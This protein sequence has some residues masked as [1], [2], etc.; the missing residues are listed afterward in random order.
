MVITDEITKKML[1]EIDEL[2]SLIP[3]NLKDPYK[4]AILYG[5]G[6]FVVDEDGITPIGQGKM[7]KEIKLR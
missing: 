3:D 6:C 2:T 4:D 5:K 7:R 1:D